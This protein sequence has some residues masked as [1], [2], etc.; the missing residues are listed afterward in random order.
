MRL[1]SR[2]Q[3]ISSIAAVTFVAALGIQ[4]VR[5]QVRTDPVTSSTLSTGLR[6]SVTMTAPAAGIVNGRVQLRAVTNAAVQVLNFD[7]TSSAVGQPSIAG[8]SSDGLNWT[9]VTDWDTTYLPQASFL[10]SASVVDPSG[11]AVSSQPVTVMV[12]AAAVQYAVAVTSPAN[13][14][15]SA[16]GATVTLTAATS[17][18]VDSLSF[19]LS[20]KDAVTRQPQIAAINPTGDKKT[21]TATWTN[22]RA[23]GSSFTITAQ[24]LLN[25]APTT[26]QPVTV[27][28]QAAAVQYTV[29]VT[30]P[31]NNSAS[32]PGATVTLTAA[33]SA[34]VD[35][36][37]FILSAPTTSVT[38]T[39]AATR[40][41]TVT[42][43]D[44]AAT[45]ATRT[46]AAPSVPA[47]GSADRK[48]WTA[49][50][51]NDRAAGSSFTIT[52]QALL[53]QAPTTSQPV[54]VMVAAP[55]YS[56]IVMTPTDNSAVPPGAVPLAAVTSQPV[57]GLV[58]VL[59]SV[60]TAVAAPQPITA[61]SRD[62]KNWT[63]VWQADYSDD[64]IF[65]VIAR[66]S[67]ARQVKNSPTNTFMF[68]KTAELPLT[69][70]VS[71]PSAKAQVKQVATFSATTSRRV[72]SLK[73][74]I[75]SAALGGKT[76]DLNAQ[77]DASGI[78][79]SVSWDTL[80]VPNGDY[81]LTASAAAGT[82]AAVSQ[83][84][85]FSVVNEQAQEPPQALAV[86]IDAPAS[87]SILTAKA[88]L[89]ASTSVKVEPL[90]FFIYSSA[91]PN[92]TP[93]IVR[94][95]SDG[96]GTRWV[97]EWDT[98]RSGDGA[99]R[100][101]AKVILNGRW[102]GES[103]PV[104]VKVANKPAVPGT[105]QPPLPGT[106]PPSAEQPPLPGT[107]PP[108]ITPTVP[109]PA[110]L[111]RVI[112]LPDQVR[113]NV[114]LSAAVSGQTTGLTLLIRSADG[115][116]RQSEFDA[117]FSRAN[118]FW[119]ALWDTTSGPDGRYTVTAAATLAD[120]RVVSSEPVW[121]V[122][123]NAK[124]PPAGEPTGVVILP[125]AVVQEA[126]AQ[127]PSGTKPLSAKQLPFD[128]LEQA[129]KLDQEC[130]AAGI[131][132]DRC[133]GWLARRNTA[134]ECRQAGILTKEE[135]IS[136]LEKKQGGQLLECA[137]QD[138][139][140]CS[141]AIARK[142]AG[143]MSDDDLNRLSQAVAPLVGQPLRF[144]RTETPP[145][146]APPPTPPQAPPPGQ[147][148]VEVRPPQGPPPAPVDQVLAANI[149]LQAKVEVVFRVQAS[150]N[151]VQTTADS[152]SRAV[153]AVLMI[154]ADGD[155][156]PDDVEKR[157]GTDPKKADTDGDG[158]SDF[159]EV[160]NGYNPLGP[161]KLGD[162]VASLAPVDTAI[163]SGAAIEQPRSSGETDP[164]LSVDH[165]AAG[166]AAGAPGLRLSGRAA[167]GQ[168]VSIFIY[169]YLPIVLT[170]TAG[171]DG[172]WTYDLDSNVTDGEHEAYVVVTEETGKIKSKSSP[173]SFFVAEAKAVTADEFY[174]SSAAAVTTAEAP[175][176]RMIYWYAG[177]ALILVI[178]A[179]VIGALIFF[180]PRRRDAG[181]GGNFF[182]N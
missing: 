117:V 179:L 43:T 62:G 105:T 93:M 88:V 151:F 36:L 49:T 120:G 116:G 118:G 12:Q 161:G 108:S 170:T 171:A 165:A 74:G 182:N 181:S 50:W 53:N 152:S 145:L 114:L 156:L 18:A 144:V 136:Y 76:I 97:A 33:T 176:S 29:A 48:T 81:Q 112:Q 64:T 173:L 70:V 157:L 167:P 38:D 51:T 32:A 149:P 148:P 44:T 28:V 4:A 94:S 85:D 106:E 8:V 17:A 139:S 3:V 42:T 132:A 180:K 52:A 65:S 84:V 5:G 162:A 82:A 107:E 13:N 79:W 23:A 91:D 126:A 39:A 98:T 35:S 150:P 60:S 63:A 158:Y 153:P 57:D 31:A 122:V 141:L 89:G 137:G 142:T 72:G 135:C 147:P 69:V 58:F 55:E 19:I 131:P 138:D 121:T 101:V 99:Y 47:N 90:T 75:A 125:P 103:Q 27:M 119:Q 177:G 24:A 54:T 21:W 96:T 163:I 7:F 87:G 113:T 22:D 146:Q 128:V 71:M 80:T 11:V 100:I 178:F 2:L 172:N 37:S 160:K 6:L 143:L 130:V 115:S 140:A 102:A 34:A 73:F 159:D 169:S 15:A 104:E 61:A 86:T 127:P 166:A 124:A 92:A 14:S 154:D 110:V 10:V 83:G 16:P 78:T 68:R 134:D 95:G 20:A 26:S 155:G 129:G 46:A 174:G 9:G 77:G 133:Q 25:Q 164:G 66:S 123:N 45:T 40:T 111:V 59:T 109:Q 175:M 56:V 30:S 41:G 1:N 168:T 67:L